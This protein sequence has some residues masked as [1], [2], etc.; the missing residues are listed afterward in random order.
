[1]QGA[2]LLPVL[3]CPLP[4]WSGKYRRALAKEVYSR[5]RGTHDRTGESAEGLSSLDVSTSP[6]LWASGWSKLVRGRPLPVA[7][8]N[9]KLFQKSILFSW[10]KND[11]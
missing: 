7:T 3:P 4:N 9:A 8:P 2:G 5:G 1:M 6:T 10:G 11:I